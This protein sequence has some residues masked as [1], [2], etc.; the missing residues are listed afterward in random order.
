MNE[1][2]FKLNLNILINNNFTPTD[3]FV[4]E[5]ILTKLANV[6]YKIIKEESLL[7][8]KNT[9][10]IWNDYLNFV[11]KEQFTNI[12]EMKNIN[13]ILKK[14]NILVGI[15]PNLEKNK[16]I[17]EEYFKINILEY[18]NSETILFERVS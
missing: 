12:K 5:Y 15:S 1:G 2:I 13:I 4:L 10:I 3:I 16:K 11:E 6:K 9:I 14:N 7:K 17:L 18:E 8:D